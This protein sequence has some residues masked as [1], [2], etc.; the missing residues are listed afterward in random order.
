MEKCQ[1]H[2]FLLGDAQRKRTKEARAAE[3]TRKRGRADYE[4]AA[5]RKAKQELSSIV[6]A[7]KECRERATR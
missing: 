1:A 2:G 4:K 7:Y 6:V 5:G 3:G